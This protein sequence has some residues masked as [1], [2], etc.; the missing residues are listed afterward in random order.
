[1]LKLRRAAYIQL[2]KQVLPL[3][4][5]LAGGNNDRLNDFDRPYLGTI[6]RVPTGLCLRV[7]PS[8]VGV[9]RQ[10]RLRMRREA[11]ELRVMLVPVRVPAKDRT[12]QQTL[13]P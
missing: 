5:N 7:D 2:G 1:L 6:E 10:A 9:D 12:S 11:V 8:K 13:P 3:V 4:M